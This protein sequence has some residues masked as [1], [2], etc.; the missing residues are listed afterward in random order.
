M[1]EKIYLYPKWIRIWH[2]LNALL[3]LI[4][5]ITGIS[6]QYSNPNVPFIRFDIAVNLHNISGVA[7]TAIYFLFLFGNIYTN[8]GKH[9]KVEKE[10]LTTRFKQQYQYYTRGIFNDEPPPYP[11][12]EK[13]KFNPLQKVSYVT[14]MYIF[15]PLVIITGWAL[16]FPESI[17]DQLFGTSGLILTVHFH[18]IIGFLLSIFMIVHIYFATIS[19]PPG[20]NYKAMATGWHEVNH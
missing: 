8:N 11:V 19:H 12:N 10:D 20:A 17:I 1:S 16:L 9:Y 7:V 2:W 4:L 5:I 15:M 14:S 13:R 3:F 6:M 18:I